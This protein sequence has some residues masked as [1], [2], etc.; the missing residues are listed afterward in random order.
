MSSPTKSSP[1]SK[2]KYQALLDDVDVKRWRENVSRGSAITSDVYL[3]RL[4]SFCQSHNTTPKALLSL[5]EIE[6]YNIVLDV[7]SSMEKAGYAGSYT[8]SVVKAIRSWLS[9]NGKDIH[10]K[11]K[12]K[13]AED[14]PTLK[15][16]RVP[17]KEELKHIFLSGD[18]KTRVASVLVAHSGV[19]IEVLGNYTGQDGLRI[20]DL[21][22]IE[23]K[24]NTVCFKRN[25]ALVVVRKELSKAGHQYFTFLSTEGCVYVQDYLEERLRS[26]ETLTLKSALVTPKLRMKPFIR[27]NNVGDTIKAAIKAGGYAWRPYVLRSYFDTQLLLA[28]SR[29]YLIRDYRSFWMGHR[30]NNIELKYTL[31]KKLPDSVI[32]DMR[33]SYGRSEEFLQTKVNE[34]TSAEK[35][36]SSVRE[37]LLL[38]LGLSKEELE[39][40]DVSS[41]TVE[42]LQDAVRNRLLGGQ[43][44]NGA[45]QK[46]VGIAEAN[47]FLAKGWEYVDKLPGDKVVIKIASAKLR[48]VQR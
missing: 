21:P 36:K 15:D 25:P 41:I 11:I 8:E 4:G 43:L 26:G 47:D 48:Q 20:A 9:H 12:I 17:T 45:S 19:R 42:E 40:I 38:A 30:G 34:E 46:V 10:R 27:A 3:R 39:K 16:E 24:H 6:L 44:T 5:S 22:E 31:D 29:G 14:A 33:A 1:D 2:C 37:Q 18:K 7:V 35:L 13:G 23:I 32:E 28:E